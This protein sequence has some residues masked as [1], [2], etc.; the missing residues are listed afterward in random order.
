MNF[1]VDCKSTSSLVVVHYLV[2]ACTKNTKRKTHQGFAESQVLQ[3]SHRSW[4]EE[5]LLSRLTLQLPP[6]GASDWTSLTP[7][8]VTSPEL[9][10]TVERLNEEHLDVTMLEL[11]EDLH[12]E[13]T[14]LLRG[15]WA[16]QYWILISNRR[17]CVKRKFPPLWS[18]LLVPSAQ[19]LLEKL[20]TPQCYWPG[21]LQPCRSIASLHPLQ[22]L[23]SAQGLNFVCIMRRWPGRRRKSN[24]KPA[25]SLLDIRKYQTEVKPI[26]PWLPFVRIV[27]ELLYNKI[28]RETIEA[29]RTVG[30]GYLLKCLEGANLA[31]MH[32]HCCTVCAK[33]I[34]LF[35]R[36]WGDADLVGEEMKSTE[37][38]KADWKKYK[39]G[40]LT[41][42]EAMVMDTNRWQK[43]RTLIRRRRQRALQAARCQ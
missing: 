25:S 20:N 41:V 29:L 22:L 8:D 19:R 43:L 12:E 17:R 9:E 16:N 3:N 18:H 27:H 33:D 15:S 14:H 26:F 32:R 6:Q 13:S 5:Q 24:P 1:I 11:V 21:G 23:W 7:S 31:C 30:E 36:L 39:E 10:R 28:T 38:R 40:H 2:M 37:A 42:E 4:G 34:W 35:R